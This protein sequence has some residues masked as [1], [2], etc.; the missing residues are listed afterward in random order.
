[1]KVSTLL[2][3]LLLALC[4]G[5]CHAQSRFLVGTSGGSSFDNQSL[6]ISVSAEVPFAHKN[7]FYIGDTFAPYESHVAL[8]SGYANIVWIGEIRWV[9][10]G[11]GLSGSIQNSSY[12]VSKASKA[13]DYFSGGPI[14]RKM[15]WGSPARLSF[16][17]IR[18]VNNGILNGLESSHLEGGHFGFTTRLGCAGNGCIRISEDFS[19]GYVLTQGN[20]VCDGAY[21]L[22]TL[23]ACPRSIAVGG[24]FTGSVSIEFPRRKGQES[25]PF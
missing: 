4:A 5:T 2:S 20:P 21:P 18:Q 3:I 6:G 17:Y 11:F 13:A 12:R 9:T 23:P 7:E 8:G 22:T 10:N 24:G 16:G 14:F 1:M 25:D 19:V 15:I